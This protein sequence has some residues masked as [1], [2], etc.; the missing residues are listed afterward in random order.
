[1]KNLIGLYPEFIICVGIIVV[2]LTDIFLTIKNSKKI[3]LRLTLCTTILSFASL[4]LNVGNYLSNVFFNESNFI[5]DNV[6]IIFK[7]IFLLGTIITISILQSASFLENKK[8]GE[9]FSLLLGALLGAML[10]SSANNILLFYLS[11]EMLSISSYALVASESTKKSK[12]AA[13]KYALFGSVSSAFMILGFSYLYGMAGTLDISQM[14]FILSDML[15]LNTNVFSIIIS[16]MLVFVGICYKISIFPFHFWAPDVYEGAPTSVAAFL[17]VVSKAAGF[18]FLLRILLIPVGLWYE[19]FWNGDSVNSYQIILGVM[20]VCSMCYG[21]FVAIRQENLK[22]LMAYSSIAHAGY[23]VLALSSGNKMAI[24]AVMFYLIVYLFM[25]FLIFSFISFVEKV[26]NKEDVVISDLSNLSKK[27][28][29]I[30]VCVF[31]AL[32]SLSGLPPTAGFSG[33]FLLFD[34]LIERALSYKEFG[35]SSYYFLILALIGVLNSV[36]SLYY[37]MKIA[38]ALFL[39]SKS[40]VNNDDSIIIDCKYKLSFSVYILLLT[41]PLFLLLNFSLADFLYNG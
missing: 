37:Y 26:K 7:L 3:I 36:V 41:L 11:F 24:K 17:S 20:A 35:A 31:I 10:I 15:T 29:L 27:I 5:L 16:L 25:N 32:I 19:Y 18:S 22:R 2:I 12:E 23:M 6:S 28:P 9:F 8:T 33:K 39:N 14:T 34:S 4:S 21:N 30:S 13:L 40:N 38:K 1:M